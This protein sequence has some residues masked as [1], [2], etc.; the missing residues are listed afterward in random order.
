MFGLV[1]IELFGLVLTSS[2]SVDAD[3]SPPMSDAAPCNWILI[4]T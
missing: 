2:D 4:H 1:P 3:D